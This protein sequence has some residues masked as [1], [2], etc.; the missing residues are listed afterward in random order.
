MQV[1][2]ASFWPQKFLPGY[3]N[4]ISQLF[5]LEIDPTVKTLQICKSEESYDIISCHWPQQIK[6]L[7]AF[8]GRVSNDFCPVKNFTA[9]ENCVIDGATKAVSSL[10]DVKTACYVDTPTITKGLKDTCKNTNKYLQIF[11]KCQ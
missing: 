8:Y 1:C 3:Q 11:Y 5:I 2:A 4:R 7:Y 6:T 9:G 10:C